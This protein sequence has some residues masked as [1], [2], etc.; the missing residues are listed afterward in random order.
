MRFRVGLA[1]GVALAAM[2]GGCPV[3]W[4]AVTC[5]KSRVWRHEH[6]RHHGFVNQ[7]T[8]ATPDPAAAKVLLHQQYDRLKNSS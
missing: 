2:T 5:R 8:A 4:R 3:T 1:G 6:V 7:S